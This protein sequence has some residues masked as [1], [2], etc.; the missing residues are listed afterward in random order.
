MHSCSR[1]ILLVFVAVLTFVPAVASADTPLAV[2]QTWLGNSESAW[3][4]QGGCQTD[5]HGD[6]VIPVTYAGVAALQVT[7]YPEDTA[8]NNGT[9]GNSP[10]DNP[11][12]QLNGPNVMVAGGTYRISGSMAF[13]PGFPAM[14]AGGWHEQIQWA[15]GP[16]YAGSPE[17][18]IMST[19]SGQFGER[20]ADGPFDWGQVPMQKGTWWH[21][22]FGLKL[23]TSATGPNC[24]WH[25]TSA[26]T[27]SYTVVYPAG[28]GNAPCEATI[29]ASMSQGP[30]RLILDSYEKAGSFPA[31]TPLTIYFGTDWKVQRTA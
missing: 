6:R 14:L 9:C 29:I 11:R 19:A 20:K 27:T 16:P 22:D 18:R 28:G 13:A 12:A 5:A 10:N 21:F 3:S 4:F 8:A 2:G 7:S 23:S 24:G 15:Y 17:N 26:Y 25:W 31:G 1:S 30:Y